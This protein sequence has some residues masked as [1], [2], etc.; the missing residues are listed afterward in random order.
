MFA[1]AGA[2]TGAPPPESGPRGS[3]DRFMSEHT[4]FP[5]GYLDARGQEVRLSGVE[6][7][8]AGIRHGTITAD[9]LLFD[10]KAE[11]WARAEYHPVFQ[12]VKAEEELRGADDVEVTREE[13]EEPPITELWR[14]PP[15]FDDARESE[16]RPSTSERGFRKRGDPSTGDRQGGRGSDE[17]GLEIPVSLPEMEAGGEGAEA[18][19]VWTGPA[20]SDPEELEFRPLP[21]GGQLLLSPIEGGDPDEEAAPAASGSRKGAALRRA[22]RLRW[23]PAIYEPRPR[24]LGSFRRRARRR[25][26]VAA[27]G[28]SLKRIAVGVVGVAAVATI[29]VLADLEAPGQVLGI[30]FAS[31]VGAG[32][33]ETSTE[34]GPDVALSAPADPAPGEEADIS[35]LR[36]A[37]LTARLSAMMER[38]D[39]DIEQAVRRDLRRHALAPAPPA[40]W[41]QGSYLAQAS[42]YPEVPSYWKELG[43]FLDRFRADLPTLVEESYRRRI[44]EAGFTGRT[45]TILL[46]DAME[47]FASR[48]SAR[49]EAFEPL[50]DLTVSALELHVLLVR[51]ETNIAYEP[52][53]KEGLSRDPVLEAVP[54][55]SVLERKMWSGLTRVTKALEELDAV[56]APTT[57]NLMG[58]LQERLIPVL[59]R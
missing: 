4:E 58:A 42:L 14:F 52:F 23:L 19:G 16:E 56:E 41:L 18:G 35:S 28:R 29:L 51:D 39:D 11:G 3:G 34:A 9:T 20:E 45:G 53:T 24:G 38:A 8:V 15:R 7:L 32:G 37:G 33:A 57:G 26:R 27:V 55:D 12:R 30:S 5:F 54:A 43:A 47:R 6:G 50:D 48:E 49:M 22:P 1:R 31:L 17:L 10:A 36:S 13:G 2:G 40:S 21:G 25:S 44:R 59:R 46:E